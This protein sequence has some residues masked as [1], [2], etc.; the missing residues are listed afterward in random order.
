MIAPPILSFGRAKVLNV[1][2]KSNTNNY[3]NKI[4]FYYKQLQINISIL[5]LNSPDINAKTSSILLRRNSNTCQ[6]L[7]M[8][9]V[10]DKEIKYQGVG[11][12]KFIVYHFRV[13][14]S[15]TPL[16]RRSRKEKSNDALYWNF[17]AAC[18]N[19]KNRRDPK[20]HTERFHLN[21]KLIIGQNVEQELKDRFLKLIKLH[22]RN[23]LPQASP[24]KLP[25]K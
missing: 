22:N 12:Y 3:K 18:F 10:N 2:S 20:E 16:R 4:C 9:T 5:H 11:T 19:Q 25:N 21:K 17:K 8:F 24:N 15:T 7:K 13:L 1:C 23:S 6:A 14:I